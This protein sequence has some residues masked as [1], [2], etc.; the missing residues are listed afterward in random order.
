MRGKF[1]SSVRRSIA[2]FCSVVAVVGM[3]VPAAG[4]ARTAPLARWSYGPPDTCPEVFFVG[5]RGSGQEDLGATDGYLGMGPQMVELFHLYVR[6]MGSH[7]ATNVHR[8]I[9]VAPIG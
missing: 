7:Y 2:V 9:A 5:V 1:K 3:T 4:W 6:A 8:R